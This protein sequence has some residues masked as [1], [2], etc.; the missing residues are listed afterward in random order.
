LLLFLFL[1]FLL[2]FLFL[3]FLLLFKVTRLPIH[4]SPRNTPRGANLSIY[5]GLTCVPP[6]TS[7]IRM[8]LSSIMT[9]PVSA[10]GEGEGEGRG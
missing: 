7:P 6:S 3:L 8:V 5:L 4:H 2:L 10:E 9:P 1:L